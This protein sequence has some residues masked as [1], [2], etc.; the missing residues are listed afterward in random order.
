MKRQ[1]FRR[2]ALEKLNSPEPLDS[3]LVLARPRT[4]W[5]AAALIALAAAVLLLE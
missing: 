3:L 1:I 4:A 2:A 5:V